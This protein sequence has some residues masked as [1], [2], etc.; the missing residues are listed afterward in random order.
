[1]NEMLGEV[2][3]LS[4]EQPVAGALDMKSLLTVEHR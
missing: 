4:S 3:S 1:M 2:S